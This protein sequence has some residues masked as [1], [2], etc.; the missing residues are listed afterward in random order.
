MLVTAIPLPWL[1]AVQLYRVLGVLFLAAYLRQIMPA[2]FALH[3]GIGDTVIGLTAPLVAY[4][5]MKNGRFARVTARCWN[6]LGIAELVLA[7][8]LGFLTPPPHSSS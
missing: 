1:I 3:A 4:A 2:E 6:V 8:V 5:V 7:V